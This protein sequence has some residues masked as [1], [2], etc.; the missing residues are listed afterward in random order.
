MS[1]NE[2]ASITP[3]ALYGLL[4]KGRPIEVIDVR[5]RAA[6]EGI[7]AEVARYVAFEGLD[8]AAV[9]AARLGDPGDPLYIICQI[10]KRSLDVCKRF[11]EAGFANVVN[12]EGGTRAWRAAGLPVVRGRGI[13]IERQV[14]ITAGSLVLAGAALGWLL[15]PAFFALSALIGAGLVFAGVSDTCPM[16][17]A[18][19]KMPW[20]RARAG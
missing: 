11:I 19:L 18:L 7:H 16:G 15:H 3:E 20:N 10:G 4:D 12:V 1:T 6:F 13:A 2:P 14:Q 5:P 8:P 17:M 9:M